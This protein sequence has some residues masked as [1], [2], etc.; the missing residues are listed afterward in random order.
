MYKKQGNPRI[1]AKCLLMYTNRTTRYVKF[2]D[3]F[4]IFAHSTE[5]GEHDRAVDRDVT[6]IWRGVVG[7]PKR[8]ANQLFF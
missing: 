8:L 3:F 7:C 6:P 2:R 4:L 5:S 1:L